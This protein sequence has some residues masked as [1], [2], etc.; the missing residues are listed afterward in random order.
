MKVTFFSKMLFTKFV[1]YGVRSPSV[2][3]CTNTHV[4]AGTDE[5]VARC[6]SSF[7]YVL[8]REF[9]ATHGVSVLVTRR[10]PKQVIWALASAE[11]TSST[12]SHGRPVEV[13]VPVKGVIHRVLDLAL[14]LKGLFQHWDKSRPDREGQLTPLPALLGAGAAAVVRARDGDG[15]LLHSCYR[16]FRIR[17]RR[18][19]YPGIDSYFPILGGSAEVNGELGC[20]VPAFLDGEAFLGTEVPYEVVAVFRTGQAKVSSSP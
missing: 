17:F 19:P 9:S 12:F 16:F 1:L 13:V 18:R 15:D 2:E 4:A 5:N 8:R 3:S 7:V 14:T 6:P 10:R 20:L 11:A